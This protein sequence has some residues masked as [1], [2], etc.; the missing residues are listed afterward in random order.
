MSATQWYCYYQLNGDDAWIPALASSREQVLR[1]KQ[2]RYMT[3]LD[4]NTNITHESEREEIDKLAYRGDLYIDIDVSKEMGGIETA[5]VQINTLID[6]FEA[7]GVRPETLRIFASGSKGFHLEIPRETFLDKEPRSGTPHLPVIYK[8]MVHTA[9]LYVDGIDNR[10][11]SAGRGRMWRST[12]AQRENGRY[13]V[14]LSLLECKSLTPELYDTLVSAPRPTIGVAAPIYCPDL[15]VMYATALDTVTARRKKIHKSSLDPAQ[16]AKWAKKPPTELQR[17]LSGKGVKEGAGWHPIAIQIALSA[18]TLGWSVDEMLERAEQAINEHQGDGNRYDSPRKRQRELVRLWYY[19]QG[20]SGTYYEFALAPIRALLDIDPIPAEY[21]D[22]TW[23]EDEEGD[24]DEDLHDAFL[25]SGV[26]VRRGGMFKIADS[27]EVRAS[28]IGFGNITQLYDVDS[29]STTGYQADMFLDGKSA[30]NKLMPMSTFSSRQALQGFALANGGASVHLNDQQVCGL[31]ELFRKKAMKND[32]RIYLVNREGLDF[33]KQPDGKVHAVYVSHE[34][35][36]CNHGDSEPRKY[37]LR[38]VGR[39]CQPIESDV[40]RAPEL[41]GTK[42]ERE[43]LDN[44]LKSNKVDIVARL[45][46]WFSAA[47]VSQAIRLR[48]NQY[49]LLHL[50]GTAGAGKTKTAELYSNLHFFHNSPEIAAAA[51]LTNYAMKTRLSASASIPLIWDEVKFHEMSLAAKHQITQYLRNNYAAV[52]SEAGMMKRDSGQS[53][54]DLREYRNSAPLVFIGETMETETAIAERYVAVP[55]TKQDRAGTQDYFNHC[56]E[57]RHLFG[58]VGKSLVAHG[59]MVD[60]EAMAKSIRRYEKEVANAISGSS[61]DDSRR[62]FNYAVVC[63][64]LEFLGVALNEAFP[65]VYSEKLSELKDALLAGI[66]TDMPRNLSEASKVL[67]TVAY[68]TKS[69]IEDQFRLVYGQDYTVGDDTVD[70]KLQNA[71]IKYQR[72]C[73]NVGIVALFPSYDRFVAAMRKHPATIDEVC[74]DNEALKDTLR[75]DVFRFDTRVLA[76]EGVEMFRSS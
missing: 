22:E 64:G 68:L 76:R 42:E 6:K 58:H 66:H 12:N 70:L 44:L 34:E 60:R 25:T 50:F 37:A 35:F 75:V 41:S 28:A 45:L 65:G 74:L 33:L 32:N 4:L 46:G 67:D 56:Y 21:R 2:P 36:H 31:A 5:I 17:L 63:Y 27:K 72:H 39:E 43:F 48:F 61:S 52:K 23:I 53:H 20:G 30:G 24:E 51:T 49:P 3:V 69:E 62:I 57:H 13:K 73:R 8:E 47:Y 16:V 11:Y 54:V 1:D 10:V 19:Y 55:L 29:G 15:A 40:L 26:K 18:T 38:S 59:L 7:L 14:Q 9:Q 71:F